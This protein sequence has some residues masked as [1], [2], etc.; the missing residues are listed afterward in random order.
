MSHVSDDAWV[1]VGR[2]PRSRD[3]EAAALVLASM[4]IGSRLHRGPGAVALSVAA[5]DA[6]R[7][8][9]E[10][11]EFERENLRRPEPSLPPIWEGADAAFAYCTLLIVIYV[12]AGRSLFG[13]DWDAAGYA[14]SGLMLGGEWW[15][16][17]TALTLHA[18]IEHLAS[19]IF[20]GGVLGLVL[21]QRVGPGL[22]WLSTLLMAGLGNVLNALVTPPEHTSIGASTAVF[23]AL[24]LLATLVWRRGPSRW[25]RG[26]RAWLPLAAGVMLLAFLGF[27]GERTDFGAHIAGFLA[28][29]CGGAALHVAGR[30]IPQGR[31][32]QHVYGL[33]AL[34]LMGVAWF[35]ALTVASGA[36]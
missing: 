10:L 23:A 7:A 12:A 4:G 6:L 14:Q 30:H 34:L 9:Y 18:N 24:G 8:G 15:R 2:Y 16:A 11:A 26:L 27:G 1:E 28:G 17:L 5:E 22:A 3:A 31:R 19:N 35:V 21:A 20:A 32:A 36:R 13:L 33:A 25:A 29:I